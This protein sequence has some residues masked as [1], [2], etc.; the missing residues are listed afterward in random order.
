MDDKTKHINFPDK[1]GH[2]GQYG[3]KYVIETLMPAL[4]E[5]ERLYNEDLNL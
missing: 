3:G 2:F 4:E 1:R 5:L